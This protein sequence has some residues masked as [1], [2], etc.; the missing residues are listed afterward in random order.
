MLTGHEDEVTSVAISRNDQFV[1]SGSYDRTVQTWD[2]ITGGLF[3]KLKDYGGKV[4]SVVV[5]PN[6]QLI[7]YLLGGE[8]W[9]WIK[10]SV[11]EHKLE[12]PPNK[13]T[14]TLPS[15]TMATEYCVAHTE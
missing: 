14:M 1:F 4:M 15:C 7:A 8:I 2:T 3:L 6:C 5:S 11:I 12:S 13:R 10:D 9:I